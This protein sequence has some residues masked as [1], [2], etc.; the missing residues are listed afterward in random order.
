MKAGLGWIDF[1]EDHRNRVFS[2]IEMLN[3]GGTVDELGIGVMRDAIADYLFPGVSTIQT[4]PKYFILI[5]QLIQTYIKDYQAKLPLQR[6]SVWFIKYEHQLMHQLARSYNYQDNNGVIGINVAKNDKQLVRTASS[7]YWNG[8]RKHNI[9]DTNY[10]LNEYL[11][12]NNLE[13]M[14]RNNM[15]GDQFD[16]DEGLAELATFKLNLPLFEETE[17]I[18]MDLTAAEAR[19][20]RDQFRDN[21]S[22]KK[23]PDNLLGQLMIHRELAVNAVATKDFSTFA[24]YLLSSGKLPA[25]T[26]RFLKLAVKFEFITHGAHIRYNMMLHQQAGVIDYSNEWTLW[27]KQLNDSQYLAEE[28][29]LDF[30]LLEIAPQTNPQT[31]IFLKNWYHGI[32]EVVPDINRLDKLVRQQEENNKKGRAKLGNKSGEYKKWVGIETLS[33]RFSQ[34]RAIVNDIYKPLED[35]GF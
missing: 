14:S 15:S 5:P 13:G 9:V 1:S 27:L 11:A 3:E 20:L 10:S 25:T 35:A 4:R 18:T 31:K 17:K 24:E 7:V 30:L 23:E 21:S 22:G 6:L 34:V 29:D 33:F 32:N 28:F 12:K 2:V 26:A 16:D 19:Y 8:I